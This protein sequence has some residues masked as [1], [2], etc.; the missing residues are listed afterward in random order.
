MQ[1][2]LELFF[3]LLGAVH[4]AHQHLVVHR[5]IKPGNILVTPEGVPK[6]L[7]FGI[8]KL[9]QPE[10]SAQPMGLTQSNMQPM[11]PNF[12][13]PEQIKG[14]PITTASDTYS[15][16]VILYQ[17]LTGHHPYERQMHTAFE[18]GQA[19]CETVPDKPSK[20][21]EKTEPGGALR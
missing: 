21:V 13:S 17:L 1:Q 20:F 8:A 5:D 3:T 6:L 4:Y 10:Y 2:R 12:A 18:L 19:I 15:L 9:L 7:D 16:G 11:T 14:Q